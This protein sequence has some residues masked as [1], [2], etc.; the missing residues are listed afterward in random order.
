MGIKSSLG[1]ALAAPVAHE[2]VGEALTP[3]PSPVRVWSREQNEIFGWFGEPRE[4]QQNL[5]IVARAGTGKTTTIIEGVNRAPE[6]FVLVTSFGR[7]IMEELDRRL[8]RPGAEAKTL[9]SLGLTMVRRHWPRMPVAKG[10]DRTEQITDWGV[11][12]WEKEIGEKI[13]F[14][15]RR[16]IGQIHTKAR[17]VIPFALNHDRMVELMLRFD[18]VPDEAFRRYPMEKVAELATLAAVAAAKTPPTKEVGI[19]FADMIF[20]PLRHNLTARDYQL[21]VCDEAQDMNMAQLELF[22]RSIDGRICV[23]GDDRQAIYG[24]RGA[25]CKSLSRLQEKLAAKELPLKTTYR[26]GHQI[27][28]YAKT[29]VPDFVAG[30]NNPE[31]EIMRS[32]F[33]DMLNTAE[34]GDFIL[35]RLNAPL[36]AITY[37]LLRRGVRAKMAGKKDVGDAITKILSKLKVSDATPIE[38]TLELLHA[39][40]RRQCGKYAAYQQDDLIERCHDQCGVL[41]AV[42][43]ECETTGEMLEQCERLFTDESGPQVLCSSVHKAKGLEANKV[44]VLM[45]TLYPRGETPEEVNIHYVA[46]TRAKETLVLVA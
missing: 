5:V 12:A 6:E 41:Y 21:G 18:L 28:G 4:D 7:K 34:E 29:L 39:W 30:Q 2:A 24:F 22:E 9:H 36:V 16:L 44:F 31:G 45:G 46:A 11:R 37:A 33:T 8:K 20:L 17:E 40:E 35:S 42:A 25:D 13:P 19:D 15:I 1:S 43:E 10:F 3:D 27:V 14:G 32:T 23:V 26:C 38:T